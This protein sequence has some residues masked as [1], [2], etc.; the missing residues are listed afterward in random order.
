MKERAEAFRVPRVCQN[1][2]WRYG[3]TARNDYC[4]GTGPGFDSRRLHIAKAA[5]AKGWVRG[6]TPRS[7]PVC[8]A[9]DKPAPR[10]PRVRVRHAYPGPAVQGAAKVNPRRAVG[11]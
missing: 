9:C 7:A 10:P 3:V 4:G 6:S 1:S 5:K 11:L 2:E 8:H